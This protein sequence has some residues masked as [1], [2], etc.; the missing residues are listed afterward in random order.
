M[1]AR[2]GDVT[3]EATMPPSVGRSRQSRL[4]PAAV[5]PT[6]APM[7]ACTSA[8]RNVLNFFEWDPENSPEYSE[9]LYL[10]GNHWPAP[11]SLSVHTSVEADEI[12]EKGNELKRNERLCIDHLRLPAMPRTKHQLHTVQLWQFKLDTTFA[13][14]SSSTVLSHCVP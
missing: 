7:I 14:S 13:A 12:S 10:G 5:T 6:T 3:Q 1:P 9:F 8:S 2:S 11:L 4:V